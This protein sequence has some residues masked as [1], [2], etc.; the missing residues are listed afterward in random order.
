MI[1]KWAE[2]EEYEERYSYVDQDQQQEDTHSRLG[3]RLLGQRLGVSQDP[4]R[5]AAAELLHH[6]PPGAKWDSAVKAPSEQEAERRSKRRADRSAQRHNVRPD[7]GLTKKMYRSIDRSFEEYLEKKSAGQV[8]AVSCRVETPRVSCP[9]DAPIRKQA[10]QKSLVHCPAV[11]AEWRRSRDVP[12][13][14]SLLE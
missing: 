5:G 1:C 2:V 14:A 13:K 11:Q 9:H 4:K 12:D 8:E 10:R 3:L 7:E 6:L